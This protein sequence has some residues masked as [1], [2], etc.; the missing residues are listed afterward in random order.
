MELPAVEKLPLPSKKSSADWSVGIKLS[1]V[2][3]PHAAFGAWQRCEVVGGG[4]NYDAND[5]SL[6]W[7]ASEVRRRYKI[8][9]SQ[10]NPSFQPMTLVCD[11]FTNWA[12][13]C[14]AAGEF[15]QSALSDIR[16]AKMFGVIVS[17][18]RT[19]AGERERCGD[20]L[21]RVMR[22]F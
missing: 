19:M 3:D 13:R 15:F 1:F 5:R 12:G 14:S 22:L 21:L 16:K 9:E 4:M 2:T 11:E 8:I 18:T 6:E 20:S 10:P 17:H 7:F